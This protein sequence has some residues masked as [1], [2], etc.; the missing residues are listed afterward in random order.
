MK[1]L[2]FGVLGC[3]GIARKH[4]RAAKESGKADV[5]ALCDVSEAI[6]GAFA[7][8]CAQEGLPR[9]A[10]YTDPAAM[11]AGADLDAV[12][13]CTPHTLH[14]EQAV[15]ALEAGC[16]VLMEK[17][18][19]TDSAHARALAGKVEQSGKV[20][21]VA[22]NTSSKPVFQYLREQIRKGT[23]GK[24]EMVNGYLSQGW[25]K[26][27]M[28]KWRQ[29]PE[30]S[31][32][33]QAY[34]SGAHIINSMVWSVESPIDEVFAFVD[35]V[36]AAVDINSIIAVRF[37]SGVLASLCISGNCP[38]NGS[39]MVF[40]FDEGRVEIDGW[41]GGWI[42]V[43]KGKEE[44]QPQLPDV[45]DSPAEN[46]FDAVLEHGEPA[47]SVQNGINHSELMDAIYESARRDAPV[48]RE[49]L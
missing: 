8:W 38:S 34:D 3:G 43:W 29:E 37:Q 10:T 14:Y 46:F 12:A 19:V 31:G 18:M 28:G 42:K 26:G 36:G 39:H 22:F 41:G 17:P 9:P 48:R 4:V 47:T 2:R 40:I 6:T 44:I 27:T 21:T 11:Y 33:G 7:D 25:L 24:L 5:V 20:F 35:N 1:K 49:E 13:I 23:F 45:A 30:L 15:Q 16:H 32:G